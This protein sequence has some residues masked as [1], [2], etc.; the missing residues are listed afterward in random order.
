MRESN[1]FGVGVAVMSHGSSAH[2][3]F[4]GDFWGSPLASGLGCW[5]G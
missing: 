4:R 3:I 5:L 1:G 2:G